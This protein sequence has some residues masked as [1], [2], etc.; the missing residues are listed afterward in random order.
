VLEG[1]DRANAVERAGIDAARQRRRSHIPLDDG[2]AA[3]ERRRVEICRDDVV[4]QPRESGGQGTRSGAGVKET[5]ACRKA[6]SDKRSG[7]FVDTLCRVDRDAFEAATRVGT[8]DL[9]RHGSSRRRHRRPRAQP[10]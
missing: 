6:G 9:L 3:A 2:D 1:L 5:G 10:G 7:V 8:M 4:T